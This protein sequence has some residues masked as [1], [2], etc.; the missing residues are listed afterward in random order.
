MSRALA[1]GKSVFD[2]GDGM[3]ECLRVAIDPRTGLSAACLGEVMGPFCLVEPVRVLAAGANTFVAGVAAKGRALEFRAG[4]GLEVGAE[5]VAQP[6]PA[7]A[8]L[9]PAVRPAQMPPLA[10]SRMHADVS[11]VDH[12]MSHRIACPVPPHLLPD[13][14]RGP[15]D[16]TRNPGNRVSPVEPPLDCEPVVE[17]ERFSLL[18][19]VFHRHSFLSRNDDAKKRALWKLLQETS[20][21]IG[22]AVKDYRYMIY[23]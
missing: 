14:F 15:P 1:V 19:S 3:L 8:A 9:A 13:Y 10:E 4:S 2:D 12:Q 11:G 21:I 17:R 5:P 23:L 22:L 20:C 16:G 6:L 7:P 18:F